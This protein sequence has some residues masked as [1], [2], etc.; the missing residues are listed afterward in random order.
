[1]RTM[2]TFSFAVM[3]MVFITANALIAQPNA[4]D[5]EATFTVA[6]NMPLK[7]TLNGDNDSIR[8]F[9]SPRRKIYGLYS[10]MSLTAVDFKDEGNTSRN[11]SLRFSFF[12]NIEY[13][14][15]LYLNNYILFYAGL[16][17]D[18]CGISVKDS[19]RRTYRYLALGVPLGFKFKLKNNKVNFRLGGGVEFPFHFK[20]KEYYDAGKQKEAE[21]F[22]K[23]LNQVQPYISA[24]A[25]YTFIQLRFKYF[26]SDFFNPDYETE[27]LGVKIKP[28]KNIT[29]QPIEISLVIGM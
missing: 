5:K 13:H 14:R 29:A 7:F 4:Q 21:Y 11:G 24:S 18:N 1:M 3:A 27:T 23:Q 17:F 9:D 20:I 26:I 8:E 12:P 22:S 15:N 2:L 25:G 10:Y 16:S 6:E 19:I 28:Y